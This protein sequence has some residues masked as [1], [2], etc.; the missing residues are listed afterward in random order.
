MLGGRAQVCTP[1]EKKRH[2]SHLHSKVA[3]GHL[4]PLWKWLN[5]HATLFPFDAA[6]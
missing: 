2:A 6:R 3:T 1:L 5:H 4:L